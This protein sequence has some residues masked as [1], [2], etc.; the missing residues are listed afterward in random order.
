MIENPK[1]KATIDTQVGR[2]ENH[3][4]DAVVR[5]EENAGLRGGFGLINPEERQRHYPDTWQHPPAAA[6]DAIRP[7]DVVKVG[8]ESPHSG[9]ERFWTRV[10]ESS[11]AVFE[12]TV[13]SV[14]FSTA[15]HGLAYGDKLLVARQHIIDVRTEQTFQPETTS[16]DT[17]EA[18]ALTLFSS[19]L[20]S[21]FAFW[22]GDQLF[23][24]KKHHIKPGKELTGYDLLVSAVTAYLLPALKQRVA[25]E[26]FDTMHN[27]I[28]AIRIDG[29]AVDR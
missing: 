25:I 22:D 20:L 26:T 6:L 18:A 14:L 16:E 7:G 5:E 1:Q 21:K 17:A 4:T 10:L 23:D 8:V 12:V 27:P 13:D 3:Q 19:S 15:E 2:F 28:R 11:E 24:W 9:G 29:T